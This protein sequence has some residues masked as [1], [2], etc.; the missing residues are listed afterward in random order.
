M[1]VYVTVPVIGGVIC[2]LSCG[3]LVLQSTLFDKGL[4]L[5]IL[6][7]QSVHKGRQ[8]IPRKCQ[9]MGLIGLKPIV[10]ALFV[11]GS[12]ILIFNPTP[13]LISRLRCLPAAGHPH[14]KRPDPCHTQHVKDR[15]YQL[16]SMPPLSPPLPQTWLQRC[17][18]LSEST[19]FSTLGPCAIFLSATLPF[20][21]FLPR[22]L[23]SRYFSIITSV[24]SSLS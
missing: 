17:P 2:W 12:R 9:R 11:D 1:E 13:L 19:Q 21:L 20:S 15:I 22:H 6:W 23:R 14:R 8:L 24:A 18:Y 4:M 10:S 5:T 3:I 16:L 7:S